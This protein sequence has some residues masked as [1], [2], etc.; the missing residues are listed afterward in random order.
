MPSSIFKGYDISPDMVRLSLVNLYLHGFTEPHVYE[1]DTLTSE[2]RWN[3]TFDVILANPPF[4]SPKGGIKPHKRFSIQAKRSEVLFVD[5]MAEHLTPNG[6]AA[7]IVP[8]GIIFQSQGAYKELRKMLVENSLVAV[9]SLPAGCFN[10]YSGVKTS[11]LILD[12]ALA[13]QSD[14]IGFFK[15]ENDGYGLGA[16][17]RAVG[18]EELTQVKA[19]IGIFLQALRSGAFSAKGPVDFRANGPASS[20]PGATPQVTD[21][22]N[23]Q[24]LKARPNRA[25]ADGTGLQP[26]K[27]FTNPEP[28][29]M[30]QA[31]MERAVGAEFTCGLIVAKEKLA[32]NGDY[33]LSGERYREVIVSSSSFPAVALGEICELARGVVF[34]KEDEVS[35][36]GVQVL[37]ANNIN[38][39]RY[40]LNLNDIK[41]VSPKADFS[42]EKKLRKG[43]VFICLASGSKDH[44]GKVAL[45]AED[46]NFYFGGFMG[47]IRVKPDRLHAGYL[48]KQLTTGHFNDFL[49]EQIAG[50]NINNLSGGLLYRFQI[51][52]P[53]LAVQQEIVAEIEGYQKVINGARAVLDHYRPHI[54]IHP[55]WAMVELSEVIKLSSGRGLTQS[56]MKTGPYIVYGGNGKNGMHSEYFVEAP[57]LVIGRVGAYCGA[58]HITAP[59][60]W[61]TDNALYVT[62]YRQ[63]IDLKYLG[64]ALV[65]LDLNQFAKVGGQPSISQTTVYE[66]SIPLPP[67][68]TQRAIVAEIEAEQALVAAN[69]ELITRFEQKI[70]TTLARVWGEAPEEEGL[71]QSRK[72]AKF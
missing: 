2:E 20:Q 23:I 69:R 60:A 53:P 48:L 10:P 4:M 57:N 46:T 49:R 71:A 33:N 51:P 17:R 1:Y 72:G 11:I 6:R 38:K 42:D 39:D 9:I 8:E 67:L 16:Q 44:V 32:A 63:K 70:Q 21:M 45:I 25:S 29:A 50:A 14:S 61:V 18:G 66:R 13:R 7:I 52:L 24:G 22:E 28:G 30:P 59:K 40:E 35:E 62:E 37:R 55:D 15:V 65:Q 64:Q 47:A 68:A 34:S 12:K 19:E 36:G 58:V 41:R 43:D 56:Q 27:N 54:P 5:Y 3:E 31:G 26:S